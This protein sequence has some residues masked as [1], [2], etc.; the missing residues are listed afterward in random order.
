MMR[1]SIFDLENG[2]LTYTR[3]NTVVSPINFVTQFIIYKFSLLLSLL[4]PR[5][6]MTTK[7]MYRNFSK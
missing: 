3:V 6:A 4:L 5:K 2:G 1:N 7:T